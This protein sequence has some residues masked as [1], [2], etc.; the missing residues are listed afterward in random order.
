MRVV[1]ALRRGHSSS[2]GPGVG[3]RA[4][5]PAGLLVQ[6]ASVRRQRVH[7][8]RGRARRG[9]PVDEHRRRRPARDGRDLRSG[10]RRSRRG[11]CHRSDEHA[12]HRRRRHPER[13]HADLRSV[14]VSRRHRG[15]GPERRRVDLDRAVERT[16]R[17]S[18]TRTATTAPQ[19]RVREDGR[20]RGTSYVVDRR[21][22]DRRV[23]VDDD[24]RRRQPRDRVHRR[25]RR[26]RHGPPRDRAAA[27]ARRQG[28]SAGRVRL[29]DLD[30]RHR[31]RLVR[32]AVRRRPGVRR[33]C[34]EHPRAASRRPPTARPPARPAMSASTRR[35]VDRGRRSDD[36]SA[37][38]RAPACSSSLVTLPDG[39][40]AAAYYDSTRRAL[41][42][43]VENAPATSQF[44][45][46]ILD[47]NV[48]GADRG[49]WSTAAVA[50]DGTIHIAYQ[51]ALGDQLMYTTWNGSPGD[52]RGRRR[53]HARRAI[54]RIP[55]APARSIYLSNGTPTIAYQDGLTADVYIA[56]KA[57]ADVDADW[58][59]RP[60]RCSTASRSR[61]RRA[62]ARRCSRGTRSTR[63]RSRRTA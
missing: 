12:V 13:R 33:R 2:R 21:R 38:A 47:G 22:R 45:E 61:P 50:S 51:D 32:R 10:P 11:R 14:D 62:T 24:R 43:S 59:S 4:R 29:D 15:R 6:L 30:G 20:A 54:A 1:A 63:R 44:T 5:L 9:R 34:D 26:R 57:G 42:L 48:P 17:R 40:L 58:P 41:V 49:M 16:R 19:V 36:R 18:R 23:R 37:A 35:C 8:G 52:A 28:R 53:R 46:T 56:A 25:R 3:D 39:R 27:R 31:A 7:G 60:A 55:S